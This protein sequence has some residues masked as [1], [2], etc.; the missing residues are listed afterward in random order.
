MTPTTH[1][2]YVLGSLNFHASVEVG[3][4]IAKGV[5]LNSMGYDA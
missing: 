5:D 4:L 2:P 3:T 1:L